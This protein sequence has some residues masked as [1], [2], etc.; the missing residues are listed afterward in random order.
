MPVPIFVEEKVLTIIKPIG[1]K[2]LVQPEK[3]ENKQTA[4]GIFIPDTAVD[5]PQIGIVLSTGD[6]RILENGTV[7]PLAV[8]KGDKVLFRKFAGTEIKID[9]D[10]DY[11]LLIT[12]RDVLGIIESAEA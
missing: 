8:K 5:K 3:K 1:D 11:L 6:G 9:K 7:M 10:E 4:S 12:E 2:V